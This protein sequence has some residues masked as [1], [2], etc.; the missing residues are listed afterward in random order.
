[1]VHSNTI[2]VHITLKDSGGIE[3]HVVLPDIK[4]PVEY[5]VLAERISRMGRMLQFLINNSL[6]TDVLQSGYPAYPVFTSQNKFKLKVTTGQSSFD[7]ATGGTINMFD[8]YLHVNEKDTENR[9]ISDQPLI[10]YYNDC[11]LPV[12]YPQDQARPEQ[13]SGAQIMSDQG[14]TIGGLATVGFQR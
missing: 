14:I 12:A 11:Y 8:D 5:K 4:R 2:S 6:T 9:P 7:V 1:M 10:V 13:C 3:R